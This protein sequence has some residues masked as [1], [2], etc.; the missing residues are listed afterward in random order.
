MG[1]HISV[2]AVKAESAFS[3]LLRESPSITM[4]NISSKV[5][6]RGVQH[7]VQMQGPPIS[8]KARAIFY[9]Q[10]NSCWLKK[11]LIS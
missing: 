8:A 11:N 10:T 4:P 6:K 1:P 3:D 7:Y 5:L 2:V 9:L